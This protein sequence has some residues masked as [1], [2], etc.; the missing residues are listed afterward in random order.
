MISIQR[1]FDVGMY[2]HA[3]E[4]LGRLYVEVVMFVKTQHCT[5]TRWMRACVQL[6][7]IQCFPIFCV[8]FVQHVFDVDVY[9]HSHERLGRLYVCTCV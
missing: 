8:I 9:A 2:A 5:S 1:V 4:R 3:H 7:C 6:V